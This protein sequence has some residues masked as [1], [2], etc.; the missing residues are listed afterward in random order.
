[1]SKPKKI[2]GAQWL[3]LRALVRAGGSITALSLNGRIIWRQVSHS[4][5]TME[6]LE[7]RGLVRYSIKDLL[8]TWTITDEG[9]A[10]SAKRWGEL[11]RA[12]IGKDS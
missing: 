7:R 12:G 2:S 5:A 11:G 3:A 8:L 6:A 4:A 10:T 9:R 1:M